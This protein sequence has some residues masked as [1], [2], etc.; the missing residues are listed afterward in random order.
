MV[1][2]DSK[3]MYTEFYSS[4]SAFRTKNEEIKAK[5]IRIRKSR[6][7]SLQSKNDSDDDGERKL[8]SDKANFLQKQQKKL[9][10]QDR[11]VQE[12]EVIVKNRNMLRQIKQELGK[13]R[14]NKNQDQHFN[15]QVENVPKL[16]ENLEFKRRNPHQ[17]LT[18]CI[19]HN[20]I[21][22][23]ANYSDHE[24]ES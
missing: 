9:D 18:L 22:N 23:G 15:G 8:G 17:S 2:F 6:D 7:L 20:Q 13:E 16:A 14:G 11:V 5:S 3:I 12:I 19:L 21:E 10:L 1:Y 24:S 4:I